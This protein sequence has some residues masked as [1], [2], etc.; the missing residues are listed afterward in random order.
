MSTNSSYALLINRAVDL[1]RHGDRDKALAT[2]RKAAAVAP[3]AVHAYKNMG[4]VGS[5]FGLP[6]VALTAFFRVLRLAPD[7]LR[8]HFS[9]A[10]MAAAAGALHRAISLLKQAVA[11]DPANAELLGFLAFNHYK[12]EQVGPA[13]DNYLRSLAVSPANA[14]VLWNLSLILSSQDDPYLWRRVMRHAVALEPGNGKYYEC[15][16]R[17]LIAAGEWG[18]GICAMKRSEMIDHTPV[19]EELKLHPDRERTFRSSVCILRRTPR[20]YDCFTFFNELDILEIRLN[21]LYDHVDLFF[22]VE[23]TKTFSNMDKPLYFL[24]NKE[25]FKDFSEKIVHI[26]L[27]DYPEFKD[28]WQYDFLQRNQIGCVLDFCQPQDFVLISDVD[29]IPR[30]SAIRSAVSTPEPKIFEMS[31]QVYYVNCTEKCRPFWPG[32]RMVRAED[33]TISAQAIRSTKAMTPVHNGGWHFT[34][35]GG[36][37]A[38]IKKIES[39]AHQEFNTKDFKDIERIKNSLQDG[40]GIFGGGF[41]PTEI[42]ETFPAYIRENLEK[43]SHL[44]YQTP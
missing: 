36:I 21:E 28:A 24:E 25:R 27:D 23:G 3:D 8:V 14:P 29:E 9:L 22:L 13:A 18:S 31:P 5:D 10:R 42:D 35:L 41:F 12:V 30:V 33:F 44:I 39:F 1:Y 2:L 38:I 40:S 26:V 11:L 15:F 17:A 34:Y 37:D 4:A 6:G 32:T 20:I 16:S 43:F 19:C 7:D